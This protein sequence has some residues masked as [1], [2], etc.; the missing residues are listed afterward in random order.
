MMMVAGMSMVFY[1]FQDFLRLAFRNFVNC[2]FVVNENIIADF[3]IFKQTQINPMLMV[4][5]LDIR[6]FSFNFNNLAWNS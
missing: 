2:Q 4:A 5:R 1:H 3:Y 6:P